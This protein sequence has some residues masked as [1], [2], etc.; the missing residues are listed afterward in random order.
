M[1]PGAGMKRGEDSRTTSRFPWAAAPV[2]GLR[3]A[4]LT[5]AA[6][7]ICKSGAV[8]VPELLAINAVVAQL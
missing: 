3:A 2:P 7:H 5:R 8:W 1:P 6:D 4:V